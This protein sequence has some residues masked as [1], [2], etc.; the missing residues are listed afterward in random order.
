MIGQRRTGCSAGVR[1]GAAAS[2]DP[3]ILSLSLIPSRVCVRMHVFTPYPTPYTYPLPRLLH[4]DM[5]E[6]GL[7]PVLCRV[8]RD[9]NPKKQPRNHAADVLQVEVEPLC[10]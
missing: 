7:L 1:K 9:F 2:P 5:K 10:R 4:D 3:V 6:S 8:M